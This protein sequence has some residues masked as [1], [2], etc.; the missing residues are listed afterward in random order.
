MV[1][2]HISEQKTHRKNKVHKMPQKQTKKK[3]KTLN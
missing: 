2:S 3:K 1:E